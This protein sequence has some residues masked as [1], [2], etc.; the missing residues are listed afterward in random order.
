MEIK[1][2][3]VT[4]EQAKLLKEKGFDAKLSKV[5]NTIGQLWNSHYSYMTNDDCDSGAACIAPE[6]W[7]AIEWLRV[8]HD[9]HVTYDVRV[10]GYY[11]LINYRHSKGSLY[12][13]K[14]IDEIFESPQK[15]YSA[16]FDYVLKEI[17]LVS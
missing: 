7:Q 15:A 1:P 14:E 4:F 8:V 9:I 6:Q 16:A 3:Y 12:L 10:S 2:T 17:A 11:G 13:S 5:Y